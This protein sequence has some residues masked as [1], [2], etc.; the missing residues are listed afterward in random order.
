MMNVFMTLTQYGGKWEVKDVR[1]FS[2]EEIAMVTKAEV[3]D[4]E[5]GNSCCFHLK[6]GNRTFI[7]MS[8]DAKSQLGDIVDIKN[9]EVITLSKEGEDDILRLRG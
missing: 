1:K 4:S 6:N 9:A 3:V 7:P 5:Y 2:D 8:N